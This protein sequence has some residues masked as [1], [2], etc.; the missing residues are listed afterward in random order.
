M[1]IKKRTGREEEFSIK[2]S[3]DSMIKAGADENIATSI[4]DSIKA[5]PGIT[6]FDV[7]QE[8][9]NEL[10]KQA[11]KSAKKFEEFKNHLFETII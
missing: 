7:R 9:L 11:P 2:K 6:T 8:V 3:Q 4:A 5:Y 1:K 10:R